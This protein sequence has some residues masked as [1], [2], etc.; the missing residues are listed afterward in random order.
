MW[1]SLRAPN[2]WFQLCKLI[3]TKIVGML[4]VTCV[5]KITS[6][7]MIYYCFSVILDLSCG[8]LTIKTQ[9]LGCAGDH[10]TGLAWWPSKALG[11][12]HHGSSRRMTIHGLRS[13][14]GFLSGA[15]F[16]A[17]FGWGRPGPRRPWG[18]VHINRWQW[19]MMASGWWLGPSHPQKTCLS[20]QP[21][22]ILG[23]EN[24]WNSQ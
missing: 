7:L 18:E 20:N 1:L 21:S 22:Q 4:V 17:R 3:S 13:T 23:E 6:S 24:V 8:S 5:K 11:T 14:C 10:L 9:A 16:P 19:W 12:A 2:I 15:R